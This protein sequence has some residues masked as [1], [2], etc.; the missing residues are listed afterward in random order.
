VEELLAKTPLDALHREL[1]ARMVP[2]ASFEM[3]IQYVGILREHEAVRK[4]AGLFDL[5]HMAQFEIFGETA[6][7][8]LDS[9]TANRVATIKPFG[10][11]YNLVMNE[12]GGVHDDIII[13]RLSDR[14]LVV[15]N[16]ANATKIAEHF[17]I[18]NADASVRIMNLH[19]KRALLALQGPKSLE[20]LAPHSDVDL[21]AMPYYSCAHGSIFGISALIA[22]TGYTGEDGFELFVENDD[23]PIVFRKLLEV[24]SIA[25]LEPTGLGSRDILR[26][27]AGMP[28]YGN[29]LGEELSP[30]Q[31]G[32]AWAVKIDKGDFT[33][34]EALAARKDAPEAK[35][36]GLRLVGKVPARAHY[37]VFADGKHVGEIRSAA[38]APSCGNV[39]IA[40]ALVD[41]VYSEL[42]QSLGIEI[43][44]T[45]YPAEVTALP[46]YRRA[47]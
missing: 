34:R 26:L 42:G 20:I 25:G 39:Q 22:R 5:S 43:R 40:T 18:H 45:L 27:E 29:E 44:G 13:Y 30:Y 17:R 1:G 28:L 16:A 7:A 6:A 38:I 9:L 15:A 46:F 19:K 23:A 47:G 12:S 31:S 41:A 33:G 36:V 3:P 10:A 8:W 11:R 35:I 4:R 32:Q 14:Y 2:F 37:P 24:G 21:A